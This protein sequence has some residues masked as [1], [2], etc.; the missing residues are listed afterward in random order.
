MSLIQFYAGA[1]SSFNKC[2]QNLTA[3][4]QFDAHVSQQEEHRKERDRQEQDNV[5]AQLLADL[6]D[7]G[8]T[9]AQ[10]IPLANVP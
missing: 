8:E 10:P 6:A 7:R 3:P 1:A 5:L 4:L 2:I 9:S